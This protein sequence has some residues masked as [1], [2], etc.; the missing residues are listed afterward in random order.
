MGQYTTAAKDKHLSNATSTSAQPTL[1]GITKPAPLWPSGPGS[2][3]QVNTTKTGI[4]GLKA[5]EY[6]MTLTVNSLN[7]FYTRKSGI[8]TGVLLGDPPGLTNTS[9]LEIY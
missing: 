5:G 4:A 2:F 7:S 1:E 3:R 6:A 9:H 8:A